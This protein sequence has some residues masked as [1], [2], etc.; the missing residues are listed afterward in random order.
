MTFIR[1][2]RRKI[3]VSILVTQNIGS[4]IQQYLLTTVKLA[5]DALQETNSLVLNG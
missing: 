5:Y 1:D 4:Y 3:N 2:G